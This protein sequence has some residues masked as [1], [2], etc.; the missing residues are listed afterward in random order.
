MQNPLPKISIITPSYNQGEY[1][2]QTIRSVLEQHYPNLEYIIIDGG[3]TDESVE[4]IKRYAGKITYWVSEKDAGQSEALNKGLRR[5]GGD[6]VAWLNSDDWYAENTLH[7][8]AQQWQDKPFDVLHGDAV[9][10]YGEGSSRT[11]TQPYGADCSLERLL[12][13]WNDRQHCNP[14]QP[15]VFISKKVLNTVGL[16]DEHYKLAMDYDLWLRI[17]QK[18]FSFR[19]VSSVLSYYRFHEDSKSGLSGYF[20]HFRKEWHEVFKKN[21]AKLPMAI[22]SKYYCKYL[23]FRLREKYKRTKKM[24]AAMLRPAV[25]LH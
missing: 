4:I 23:D 12:V 18:G 25:Y 1:L 21:L 7:A 6:I 20:N 24:A 13:Y 14:P 11:Y 8:V 9:F 19:Y 3:S 10:Y 15:S 16:I 2:E 5:A 22:R 17:A